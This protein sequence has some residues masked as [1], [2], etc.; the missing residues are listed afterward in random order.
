MI[1]YVTK[2]KE[3]FK[4]ERYEIISV[5]ES[6]AYL[7]K[8]EVVG[9]DTETEGLDPHSKKLLS[10]QLGCRDFQV[11][12]D[13]TTIDPL[14]YKEYLESERTFLLW[15][16][17]F[18]LKFLYKQE[19]FPNHV[20]DLMLAEKSIYIGYPSG[21][22]SMALKDAAWKYLKVSLDK[23]VRG[24]IITQGLNEE[25]ILYS[26]RDVEYLEDIKNAQASEIS[27]Q[28]LFNALKLENEFVKVNAYFEFCGAKLDTVKW[29]QKMA[30][31]RENLINA[32]EKL[33]AWVVD[34]ENKEVSKAAQIVYLDISRG[35]GDNII[36]EDREKLKFAKRK[37]E[38]DIRERSGELIAEAYEVGKS[39][40]YSLINT[41]GS[42]FDGFDLNPKCT[43]NWASSKQVIA[44]F[45]E[46]GINCTTIDKKTKASR[47]S[48]Q[49]NVIAP[50]KGKFPIIQLYLDY[51]EA[52]KVVT[53]F[54]EKFLGSINPVTGR[55]H[56]QFGQLGTDTGYR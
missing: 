17:C 41:Q 33:D 42:L 16:A 38:S 35:R 3:L 37:P 29:K 21:M 5:E 50:Q 36:A 34:W 7:N 54:G 19:I 52:E 15:N 25:T 48:V 13:C 1:Y 14:L 11:V 27:K 32:K 24:K 2:A 47:E 18:D 49:E 51:K 56:S 40:K 20:W 28:N 31:D 22:H 4:S 46:L 30:K 53:S 9:C 45:K 43:I 55:I 44:L 10:L 8:L 12:I 39:R 23:T 26:A 6:L